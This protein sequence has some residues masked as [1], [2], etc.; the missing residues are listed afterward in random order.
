[1]GTA[2]VDEAKLEAFMGRFVE[3]WA[4]VRQSWPPVSRHGPQDD[5]RTIQ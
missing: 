4:R 3:V 5:F 1:M 2:T